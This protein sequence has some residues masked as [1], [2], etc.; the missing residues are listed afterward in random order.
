MPRAI[1]FDV[2]HSTLN[3][4]QSFDDAFNHYSRLKKLPPRDLNLAYNISITTLRR[5]GQIDN[6]IYKCLKK[7]LPKKGEYARTILR[8][9]ICQLLF[10]NTPAHAAVDTSV[11]L[12]MQKKQEVYKNLINA[13]LRRVAQEGPKFIENQDVEKLNTPDWLWNSWLKEYGENT[14]RKIARAHLKMPALDLSV[15]SEPKLW[16]QKLGGYLLST[17]SIRLLSSTK[18]N[19]LDG[20]NEGAWWVQD[21]AASIPVQLFGNDLKGKKIADI[22]AA[23]GG[24]TAQLLAAGAEVIALDRSKKRLEILQENLDRLTFSPE[25]INTDAETWRPKS[26]LDGVL[27]DAPCSSTGT[28]R[29]NPD[30][31]YQKNAKIVE[32]S[33]QTQLR[34]LESAAEMVKPSGK[35]VFSTCSLQPE[36]GRSV[37]DTFL[38]K[39]K[40]WRR[41]SILPRS[42]KQH[43]EFITNAGDIRTLPFYL[44][45]NLKNN[46]AK[47]ISS[48]HGMDGFFSTCLI[49]NN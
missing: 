43:T 27:I 37:I 40:N 13:I 24:K 7:D 41:R 34:L 19:C 10:L 18:I 16:A 3:K 25:V 48:L 17:G 15:K 11:R 35:I 46:K 4:N 9:G 26:L 20:F 2:I 21:A 31:K 42:L 45:N 1:T 32:L 29:R 8:I 49:Q 30:I 44:D 6:I 14:T 38:S 28:I 33:H 5:L 36:E 12:A 22:G 23:P 47:N 39:Y